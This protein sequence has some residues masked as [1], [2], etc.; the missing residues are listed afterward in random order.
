MYER[1]KIY[2][3]VKDAIERAVKNGDFPDTEC[4]DPKIEYPKDKK[5]GDYA[6]PFALETAKIFRR[7]PIEIGNVL[8][9]YIDESGIIDRVDVVQPGFINMFLNKGHLFQNL[10]EVKKEGDN[11]GRNIKDQP[12]RINLEFISANPTG[13]LNVVSARAAALGDTLANLL[14]ATGD[15]VEREFYVND[16][17]NQVNMLGLSVLARIK[18]IRGEDFTFPE[19]GYHGEYV[20]DIARIVLDKHVDEIKQYDNEEDLVAFLAEKAVD[21]NVEGQKKSLRKFNVEFHTWFHER[22]LH[23]RGDV[24]K[25]LEFLEAR[26]A[27]YYKD[28]KKLFKATDFHDDKD[29][30]VLRDDGRPT[31]LLADIAYHRDKINRGYDR[32]INIWGPDHHGY[33]ARLRGAVE[34][35]GF[36]VNKFN[37]LIAQ[38]VNLIIEGE[39]VKMSKRLGRFSTMDDLL[40]EIDPDVA[41]YF[42]V[43]RSME[44]H[45]D[46]DL[47][48]AK[49]ESSENPVFYLQYA[50]ARICSIFREAENRGVS[51]DPQNTDQVH[52]DNDES[53]I[54]MKE[55]IKFPEEIFDAAENCEPHRICTFLMKLAQAFHKFYTE[56]R[57]LSDDIIGTNTCLLLSDAVRTVLKNGLHLLGVSAPE[58]M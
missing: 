12:A 25:T 36:D 34:A 13:P 17:G 50:H 56:H 29:R 24:M 14:E 53:L 40:D 21:Y 7:S 1:V 43:M 37:I 52:L 35:M 55:L 41:R 30:V 39:T 19:E 23:D 51:Y 28:E 15:D 57:V 6:T 5:F 44:S 32:L 27:V 2:S 8:K 38:Q 20:K 48:L 45:L 42:F 54:L 16:Y 9:K 11:Y 47:A 22:E 3:I 33:I 18:E 26:N 46:F 10:L 49:K 4:P 31:Y 58:R